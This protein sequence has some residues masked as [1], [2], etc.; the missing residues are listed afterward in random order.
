M[1]RLL[2]AVLI[3]SST[4]LATP[5][6][7]TADASCAWTVSGHIETEN[8][9][10]EL[11]EAL[12]GFSD[13]EGVTVRVRG[14]L[15]L[16]NIL[17]NAVWGTWDTWQETTTNSRGEFTV[18]HT[19][20]LNPC[21]GTRRIRVEVK[22]QNDDLEIRHGNATS[23]TTKVKWVTIYDTPKDE[24]LTD[25]T[26]EINRI[27]GPGR[28]QELDEVEPRAHANMWVVYSHLLDELASYGSAYEFTGQLKV[29]YPHNSLLANEDVEASYA[30]PV[31]K[32]VYIYRGNVCP[33]DVMLPNETGSCDDHLNVSTLLHEAMHIWAYQH[34]SGESS[35]ALNL[36]TTGSTHCFEPTHIAFHEG[37]A[38]FAAER[39]GSR[40]FGMALP[41]PVRRDVLVQGVSCEGKSSPDQMPT[42][43]KVE[44]HDYGWLH[45]LRIL[46]KNNLHLFTFEGE[47]TNETFPLYYADE[48]RVT[49]GSVNH[50]P[51][52]GTI[53]RV[54]SCEAPQVEFK[55]ILTPFLASPVHGYSVPLANDDLNLDDFM[56][57]FADVNDLGND[58]R[59]AFLTLID[60]AADEQPMDLFC[61][62]ATINPGE[63]RAPSQPMRR[64]I[65]GRRGN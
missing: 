7:N 31:T 3:T 39:L 1:L 56:D 27:F 32:V 16:S 30:N 34:S 47:A 38:E 11:A 9:L 41:Q 14:M 29:K 13:L 22:F 60:P 42:L 5:D 63:R 8:E 62:G 51:K 17:G 12:G 59:D 58:T 44:E 21:D 19:P 57:R 15:R 53:L 25:H 26:L 35:L 33:D 55:D 20:S 40:L 6:P 37:F 23:S 2:L 49:G 61:D 48:A 50:I 36:L 4:A 54:G 18:R 65:P 43:S 45:A 10:P 52:H 64:T 28:V 24:P 46:V